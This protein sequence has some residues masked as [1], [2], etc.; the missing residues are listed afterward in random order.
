MV[1]LILL[2]ALTAEL[3]LYAWLGGLLG[4][5]C[6]WPDGMLV[7]WVLGCFVALRCLFAVLTRL[8]GRLYRDRRRQGPAVGTLRYLR[9]VAWDVLSY[10][11]VFALAQPLEVLL[12]RRRFTASSVP[13]L[14]V[15]GFWCNGGMWFAMRRRLEAA[16]HVCAT[17]NLAPPTASIE[18]FV[19]Q[20]AAAITQLRAAT[21]AAK[22]RLVCH[23]MGG[24]VTRAYLAGHGA[25]EVASVITLGTPHHG[26]GLAGWTFG[27]GAR[28]MRRQSAWLD[29]LNRHEGEA[30]PV[31]LVSVFSWQ[32]N[33]VA[34]VTSSILRG[35][36]NLAVS[37]VGHVS[38]P[39]TPSVQEIVLTLLNDPQAQ[40]RGAQALDE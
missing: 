20:L 19:P 37:G 24:L 1:A 4:Q 15:H 11:L 16:G 35:A 27:G 3:G 12:R 7:L 39:W 26:S 36:R 34:P 23:S 8:V 28:Q 32:D 22:V 17:V 25:D 2:F 9:G 38:M 31:P 30:L 14:L 29:A 6:A 5:R 18:K 13:V 33:L 21:G 10:V 40:V